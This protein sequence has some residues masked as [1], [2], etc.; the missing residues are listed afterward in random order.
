MN[1]K[2]NDIR[3]LL[4]R[5]FNLGLFVQHSHAGTKWTEKEIADKEKSV[6]DFVL[7][8]YKKGVKNG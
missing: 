5:A 3:E 8:E 2:N 1:I 7:N 6:V 4:R